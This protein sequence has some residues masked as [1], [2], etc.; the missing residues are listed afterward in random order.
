V[1]FWPGFGLRGVIYEA[2]RWLARSLARWDPFVRMAARRCSIALATAEKTRSRLVRLGVCRA[3]VVSEVAFP[4]D[5]SDLRYLMSLPEASGHHARFITIG[6]LI[7]WKGVH[8]ALHAFARANIADAEYWIVGGGP[9][10]RRLERLARKLG[11]ANRVR[12]LGAQPRQEALRLLSECHALV[13][14]SLHDSGGWACI[15]A[16]AAGRPVLCLNLGGPATQ[17]TAET[18]FKCNVASPATAIADLGAAMTTVARDRALRD[19]L[20]KGGRK[21]ISELFLLEDRARYYSDCYWSEL[22]RLA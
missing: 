16:M 14:P 3:N 17:V 13:H 22:R 5:G 21:R 15:E 1:Q 8:L 2:A 6:R 18:G 19:L 20:G 10:R 9:D 4:K 12:F 7:H 11:I